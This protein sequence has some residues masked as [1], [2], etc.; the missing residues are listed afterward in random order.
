MSH[1]LPA[2]I[3]EE[4]ESL[5]RALKRAGYR[6]TDSLYS[7]QSFGNWYFEC[8]GPAGKLRFV[9]DRGYFSLDG[10]RSALEPSGLWLFASQDF[11]VFTS[12]VTRGLSGRRAEQSHAEGGAQ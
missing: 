6:V 8:D 3:A 1:T 4:A 7:P 10:E 5:V 11:I 9:K 2:P 12:K